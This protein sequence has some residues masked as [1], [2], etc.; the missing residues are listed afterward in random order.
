V[1]SKAD[2]PMRTALYPGSFDPPTI[3]HL[4]VMR[5]AAGLCDHL[6][7]AVGRHATKLPLLDHDRRAALI[8][9]QAGPMLA[10]AGCG[11]RVESFSGLA[12]EAARKFGATL[13]V[14]GLRGATDLDSEMSMAGMNAAMASGIQTVLIPASPGTRFVTATLV[15]QIASMGGDVSAFVTPVVAI[16]VAE[17][18]AARRS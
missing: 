10:A 1:T 6:V 12:I 11:L 4:D 2:R 18:I 7:V 5:A 8:R 3:G 14:R 16:A 9:D 15:R 17:A 13:I